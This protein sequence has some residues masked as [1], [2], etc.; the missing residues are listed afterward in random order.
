MTFFKRVFFFG[1]FALA[2]VTLSAVAL[3]RF[4][5]IAPD[6]TISIRFDP[7]DTP[8]KSDLALLLRRG[9]YRLQTCCPHSTEV[10]SGIPGALGPARRFVLRSSDTPLYGGYRSELRLR[11]NLMGRDF[12][13]QGR[14]LLPDDWT[15]SSTT[16]NVMQWH[17][18][19]DVIFG[20]SS[21]VPPLALDVTGNKWRVLK[22]WDD[23]WISPDVPRVQGH[24]VIVTSPI[25][26]GQWT[27]WTFHVR[28]SATSDGFVRIWKNGVPLL[29][30]P[31]PVGFNDLV[32]PYLKAG[33]YIP[34]W[35]ENGLEPQ[36]PV[37]TLLF[38]ELTASASRSELPIA[39]AG[40]H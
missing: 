2:L 9:S 27:T 1:F 16:V 22:A 8:P 30:L 14:V 13:Y 10:V 7:S 6:D 11:P 25:E 17:G 34:G 32:G 40:G 38:D 5:H 31:G 19:R 39:V 37:R 12:W 21:T 28:W 15:I 23:R 4:W 18:T 3:I 20:E 26:R 24:R 35:I 29:D 33:L 36:V